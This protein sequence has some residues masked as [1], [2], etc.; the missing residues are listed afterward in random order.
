M[1]SFF[2]DMLFGFPLGSCLV[3]YNM[4]IYCIS[5]LCACILG[6]IKN[7]RLLLLLLLLLI[8]VQRK[9]TSCLVVIWPSP[10]GH[11]LGHLA[12]T[13]CRMCHSK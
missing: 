12:D 2:Y 11:T 7:I 6:Q 1:L 13:F 9:W 10:S 8:H 5:I 3:K 4:A